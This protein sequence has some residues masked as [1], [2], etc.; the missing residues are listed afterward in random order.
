[1]GTVSEKL[2]QI[3]VDIYKDAINYW[4]ACNHKSMQSMDWTTMI[5]PEVVREISGKT[6]EEANEFLIPYL[7][8][9]H[10]EKAT[11]IEQFKEF[12][13]KEFRE[14]FEAGCKKLKQVMSGHE[15]YRDDFTIFITT[16]GRCPYNK[17]NGWVWLGMK[18]ADPVRTFLHELCHFQFIHY[19]QENA[20]SPISKITPEE[21]NYLK[22]SLT[23]ILDEDFFPIIKS[24]DKGY[25]IHQKFRAVLKKFWSENKDFNALVEYGLLRLQ[26]FI[27]SSSRK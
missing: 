1:M 6:S 26:E 4:A 15:L 9:K 12:V 18:N 13:S 3:K 24:A 16:I 21:F 17:E 19:W 23:M 8:K 25:D 20:D 27:S 7:Q 2:P 10:S 14:K 5:E 22:E 11:E